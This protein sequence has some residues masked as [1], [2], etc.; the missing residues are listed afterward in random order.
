[1]HRKLFQGN[2]FRYQMYVLYFQKNTTLFN[3]VSL[4]KQQKDKSTKNQKY[5][6]IFLAATMVLSV[7][8]ALTN[9][10]SKQ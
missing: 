7:F 5:L 6:A 1:M 8:V 10:G 2:I 4:M 3:E 9:N